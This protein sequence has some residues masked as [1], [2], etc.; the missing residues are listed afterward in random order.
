[1]KIN[2]N[3]KDRNWLQNRNQRK[4]PKV[5]EAKFIQQPDGSFELLGGQTIVYS[6]KNQHH[7]ERVNVDTRDFASELK[8]RG[9]RAL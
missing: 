9:F 5:F 2:N 8:T 3:R 7:M 4:N 6:R 1:M